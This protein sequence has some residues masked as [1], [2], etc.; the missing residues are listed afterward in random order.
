MIVTLFSRR[1]TLPAKHESDLH[2]RLLLSI[3]GS[4][5]MAFVINYSMNDVHL[6]HLNRSP[7]CNESMHANGDF[8]LTSL[9]I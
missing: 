8:Q 1:R 5:G 9:P 7:H 6:F 4:L 2:W 3:Y